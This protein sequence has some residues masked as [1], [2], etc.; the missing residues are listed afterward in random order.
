MVYVWTGRIG[1]G[2][3]TEINTTYKSAVSPIGKLL[4]PEK[5]IVLGH[6]HYVGDQRFKNYCKVSDSE[7]RQRYLSMLRGH[8]DGNRDMFLELLQRHEI[9]ITCYCGKHKSFCH[10]YLLASYVL[11]R[12]ASYFKLDYTYM[13]ER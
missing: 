5:T 10:R 6:K 12:C 3:D 11:P 2:K 9:T 4:A 7:Y 8:F 1:E 13:G